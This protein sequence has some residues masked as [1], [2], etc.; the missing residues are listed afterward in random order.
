MS[1]LDV[2]KQALMDQS[3]APRS[4]GSK[5]MVANGPFP[6]AMDP[7]QKRYDP[8]FGYENV[9][10]QGKAPMIDW[11]IGPQRRADAANN[12]WVDAENTGLAAAFASLLQ[13]DQGIGS[14]IGQKPSKQL[15][16]K[17]E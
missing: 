7:Y 14:L 6:K 10:K 17:G 9:E 4:E 5:E 8:L 15:K 11:A 16:K 1:F 13:G 12:A 3:Q 2:I